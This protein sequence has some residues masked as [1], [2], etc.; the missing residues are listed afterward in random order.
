MRTLGGSAPA[1][2]RDRPCSNGPVPSGNNAVLSDS[3]G[4]RDGSNEVLDD[5]DS[6]AASSSVVVAPHSSHG[7]W[8]RQAG[9]SQDS[10]SDQRYR[11]RFGSTRYLRKERTRWSAN[12]ALQQAKVG[13]T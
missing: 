5:S 2:A 9:N 10:H 13:D 12:S 8:D 6:V 11:L 1:P 3:S 4:E 7:C